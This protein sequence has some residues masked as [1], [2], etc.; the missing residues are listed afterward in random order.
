MAALAGGSAFRE[1]VTIDEVA[2][3]GAG[4]SYLQKLD[5]RMNEEHPPLAKVIV[6]IPLV[7]R[8]VRADY[9]HLSWTFSEKIPNQFLGEWVFGHWFLMRWNDPQSTLLW[10]RLPMLLLTLVLGL[11]IYILGSR[12]GGRW[13]GLLCLTAYV[14]TPAF[15]TFGPLVLTDVAVTL[16]WVLTTWQ[17]AEMWHLPGRGT[18]I[19]FGLVFAGALLT[20]FSSGLLFFVFAAVAVSMR[21]RPL[22][23]QP[24]EKKE[25]R[26]WRRR[27]WWNIAKGISWAALFV[28][29]TYF[30]LSW[31][32]PTDSFSLIHFPASPVL[33]RLFM[34]VWLYLR[35]VAL[36]AASAG[37][38]PT[39]IL[40]HAYPHGV[41]FY[42]PVLFLLKSQLAF[43]A[44]ALL[45]VLVAVLVKRSG[46]FEMLAVPSGMALRWRCLWISLTV[47]TAACLLSR[48]DI[49]IRHFLTAIALITILLAPLPRMLQ[50]LRGFTP[51]M[52]QTGIALTLVLAI[53]AVVS[54]VWAYPNY[55]PYLNVLGMGRPG[56]LLV[57]DS[58]LDWN[59]A[60][61]DAEMFARQHGLKQFLLDQYGFSE[62]DAWAPKAKLWN[63]QQPSSADAGEWAVVSTNNLVDSHNCLWLM[64]YP[65]TEL[66]AGSMFAIQLPHTIPAAGQPGGP[67]L[68]ADYRFLAGFPNFD[69]RPIFLACIRDP[70]QLQP[71]MDFI[72]ATMQKLQNKK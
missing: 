65:H 1:S 31:N 70:Q 16:F 47:F 50:G 53:V 40:G 49:S 5:M 21:L 30:V 66:A 68:P 20:K 48:L 41:W 25:R 39:Y 9:T 46:R 2:H 57:N 62:P 8:G 22:P 72:T 52:A 71:T 33:R 64:N 43:L 28:Y 58:N 23:E 37:S 12:L 4:V 7:L 19:T 14:T 15:L 36:F 18:L 27:G 61:P 26:A 67:P 56:Y 32:E 13:G 10:A 17:L 54:A 60:L 38:R 51:K 29:L 63:C 59:Q 24:V 3:M 35:G 69:V 45:A 11:T 42:F 34:P 55:L 44:L 6:A